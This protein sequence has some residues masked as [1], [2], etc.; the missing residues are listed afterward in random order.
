MSVYTSK[1][2]Y[3]LTWIKNNNFSISF[4]VASILRIKENTVKFR[5]YIRTCVK[6]NVYLSN[7][8]TT[9]T[10]KSSRD[11][12]FITFIQVDIQYLLTR[13]KYKFIHI[14]GIDRMIKI[15][16]F[17]STCVK[18]VRYYITILLK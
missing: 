12:N 2:R 13:L 1:Y 17:V 18:Y 11:K 7:G 14:C 8:L 6:Y 4:D 10:D 3:I 5:Y 9:L 16:K 15:F